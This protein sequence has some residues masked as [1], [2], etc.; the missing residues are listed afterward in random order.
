LMRS[1][2]SSTGPSPKPRPTK[3]EPIG[4]RSNCIKQCCPSRTHLS[5]PLASY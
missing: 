5:M 1:R 4:V 3:R 2:T